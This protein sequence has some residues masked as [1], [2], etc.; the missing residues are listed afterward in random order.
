MPTAMALSQVWIICGNTEEVTMLSFLFFPSEKDL[1]VFAN[2][3]LNESVMH[4]HDKEG[5]QPPGLR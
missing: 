1:G 4:L 3:K 5:Q 2:N